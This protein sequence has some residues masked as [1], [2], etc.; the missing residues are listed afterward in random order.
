MEQA[1][2]PDF[3]PIELN[4]VVLDCPDVAALSDF[5]IRLL[6]W[7]PSWTLDGQWA[8][9]AS[10]SGG[11]KLGFQKN[12]DYVPPVWPEA[13][14]AQQQMEHLDFRVAPEN[15]ERAVAHALACGAKKAPE[16]FSDEWVVL[17][18]PV[19]HPFCFV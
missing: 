9:I 15:R 1:E 17:L 4:T 10:P 11:V 12:E 14:G 8:D 19:G 6:G 2:Q 7:K 3:L 5:Y 16:Q 13:P 18:D